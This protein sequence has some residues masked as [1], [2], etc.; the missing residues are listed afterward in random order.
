MI[1]FWIWIV[2]IIQ[3]IVE[4]IVAK[5]NE[6]WMRGKGANVVKE[7]HYK[8]I[9]VTHVSFLL[10]VM[11]EAYLSHSLTAN[12][13]EMLIISFVL[14]QLF[15][16]WCL[17]SLGRFWN[18]RIIILPGAE[19][20]KKGPYKFIN[21]PNYLVVGLEFI[22]IPLLFKAYIAAILFPILHVILMCYRI[23]LENK[24]LKEVN[25]E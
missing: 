5:S 3:R 18:T 22:V 7:G 25:E 17:F 23:P 12:I 10:W 19:L 16:L 1:Y 8:W 9:V 14:L 4:L 13:G 2:I 24:V 21:H 11:I 20:V 15:R 6:N